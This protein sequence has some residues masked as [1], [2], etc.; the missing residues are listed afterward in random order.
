MLWLKKSSRCVSSWS[1]VLKTGEMLKNT[2]NILA[3][4]QL[5]ALFESQVLQI[6]EMLK[7]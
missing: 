6:G 4:P 3:F 2:F 7:C 1:K 5:L